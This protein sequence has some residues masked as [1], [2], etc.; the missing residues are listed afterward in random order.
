MSSKAAQELT[1]P[2]T[3]YSKMLRHSGERYGLIVRSQGIRRRR[4]VLECPRR[5]CCYSSSFGFFF[6][7]FFLHSIKIAILALYNPI[8]KRV[9]VATIAD[10]TTLFLFFFFHRNVCVSEGRDLF[11]PFKCFGSFFLFSL[12][13]SLH[14]GIPFSPV[15]DGG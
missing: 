5:S 9:D 4:P 7:S 8:V 3:P 11:F 12:Y 15:S 1:S 13:Y 6:F 10:A 14:D 2:P